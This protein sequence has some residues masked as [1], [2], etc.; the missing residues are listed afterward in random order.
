MCE[1]I[2][3]PE[4]GLDLE[5]WNHSVFAEIDTHYEIAWFMID[6]YMNL[7]NPSSVMELILIHTH[8]KSMLSGL[9]ENFSNNEL[10]VF[11]YRISLLESE[12]IENLS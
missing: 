5:G 4:F 11:V 3:K 12:I 6:K 7:Q 1:I 10:D 9:K 8:L 2:N